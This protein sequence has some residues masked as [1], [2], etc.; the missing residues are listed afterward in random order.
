MKRVEESQLLMKN[1]KVVLPP[2]PPYSV[3]PYVGWYWL[4]DTISKEG[5]TKDLESMAQIGIG[6]AFI[7][8]IGLNDLPYR[9]VKALKVVIEEWWQMVELAVR[10][11]NRLGLNIGMFN[12]PGWSQSGDPWV[13]QSQSVRYYHYSGMA[14]Y[15]INFDLNE[16]EKAKTLFLNLG[17]VKNMTT[18]KT[19]GKVKGTVWFAPYQLDITNTVTANS[20]Q[21]EI[22]V[23]KFWVNRLIGDS[24]ISNE[25]RSTWT[26]L[27]VFKSEDAIQP[28]GLIDSARLFS[29]RSKQNIPQ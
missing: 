2:T 21:L 28:S 29:Y 27:S 13:K 24:K 17:D 26:S 18:I 23:V 9:K 5:I 12:S 1:W 10:E 19:N 22:E 15:R 25:K 11:G 8:N 7:D 16:R 20:N 4:S 14:T 6:E 3:K